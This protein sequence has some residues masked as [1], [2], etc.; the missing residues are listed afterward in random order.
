MVVNSEVGIHDTVVCFFQDL[1]CTIGQREL[2]MEDIV[3][4]R[5]TERDKTCL[6]EQI[7][8]AEV[9]EALRQLPNTKFW[10]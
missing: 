1:F 4:S 9:E 3:L 5:V 8:E 10:D 7:T 6:V 2:D